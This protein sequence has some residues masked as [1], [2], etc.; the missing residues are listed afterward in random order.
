MV[1]QN[2]APPK[3]S[4]RRYLV[5]RRDAPP[6]RTVRVVR[7]KLMTPPPPSSEAWHTGP[8][9]MINS[10]TE[11]VQR[12]QRM[13]RNDANHSPTP[14]IRPE[15]YYLEAVPDH[16]R[17]TPIETPMYGSRDENIPPTPP[18]RMAH[19]PVRNRR[20]TRVDPPPPPPP[21]RRNPRP[22][23]PIVVKRVYKNYPPGSQ[24]P[25]DHH[26]V[27]D[28]NRPPPARRN[29][30]NPPPPPAKHYQTPP[31]SNNRHPPPPA[32]KRYQSPPEPN[33][34]QPA[35]AKRPSIFYIRNRE[36]YE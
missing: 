2:G 28:E 34:S 14:H 27:S 18:S 7:R 22:V 24:G 30:R 3:Q 13:R 31:E 12:Q 21:E 36:D 19:Q 1:P 9:R 29:V 6:A 32:S 8:R 20:P 10:D 5:A 4:P 33:H 25:P 16:V 15:V 35:P 11:L 17:R 26:L 23:E